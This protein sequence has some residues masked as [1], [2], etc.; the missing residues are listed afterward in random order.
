MNLLEGGFFV[1]GLY[2]ASA[3]SIMDGL[4]AFPG[5]GLSSNSSLDISSVATW[6]SVLSLSDSKFSITIAVS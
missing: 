3:K 2:T 1:P 6:T 5:T 4:D